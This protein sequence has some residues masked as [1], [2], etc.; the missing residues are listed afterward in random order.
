MLAGEVL[1][2]IQITLT[3]LASDSE[4]LSTDNYYC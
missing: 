1:V 4:V 3:H 2:F